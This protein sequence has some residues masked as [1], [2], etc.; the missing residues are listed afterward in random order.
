MKIETQVSDIFASERIVFPALLQLKNNPTVRVWALAA[1]DTHGTSFSGVIVSKGES[2]NHK[3]G[4]FETCW[5]T[6]LWEYSPATVSLTLA[7]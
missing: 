3:E 2:S 4:M 1:T 6:N 5:S 7:N